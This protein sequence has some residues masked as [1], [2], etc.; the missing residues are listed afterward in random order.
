M[1]PSVFTYAV[2]SF[3]FFS[4]SIFLFYWLPILEHLG[5]GVTQAGQLISIGLI[6]R[7]FAAYWFYPFCIKRLGVIKFGQWLYPL[8]AFMTLCLVLPIPLGVKAILSVLISTFLPVG[9]PHSETIGSAAQKRYDTDYEL[10]RI[11]GSSSFILCILL[12]S[13]MTEVAGFGASLVFLGLILVGMSA[14]FWKVRAFDTST[15]S[16]AGG[17][18]LPKHYYVYLAIAAA[19]QASHAVYYA[20]GVKT[21]LDY[22]LST[23]YASSLV[24]LGV[25]AE[26]IFYVFCKKAARLNVLY[27]LLLGSAGGA[28]RW[29]LYG[30]F[31]SP[32]LLIL[33][34]ALHAF[35][36]SASHLGFIYYVSRRVP[37]YLWPKAYGVYAA[38]CMSFATGAVTAL[39]APLYE[40]SV[41]ASFYCMSVL[42][43]LALL[44]CVWVRKDQRQVIES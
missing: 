7:G 39:V 38:V 42:S 3:L 13:V 25:V 12:T 34:S 37:E 32:T 33:A 41:S 20:F 22:G 40:L 43:G 26:V 35:S 36:F 4:W 31:S 6:T 10:A 27:L 16:G 21:F 44:G 24:A 5:F 8:L 17:G 19:L 1:S 23:T 28:V 9:I 2:F 15:T 11:F 18:R 29:M 14:L 30:S